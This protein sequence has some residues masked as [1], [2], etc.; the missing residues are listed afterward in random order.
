M[1]EPLEPVISTLT[2]REIR[3]SKTIMANVNAI[4]ESN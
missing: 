3:Q 4:G 1:V 2:A